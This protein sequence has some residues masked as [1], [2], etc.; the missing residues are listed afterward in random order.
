MAEDRE[1]LIRWLNDAHAMEQAQIPVL[2]NHAK[3]A[4]GFPHIRARDEQHVEE[5]RRHAE[6]VRGCLQRLGETPSATKSLLG[7][8]MGNV[9]SVMTGAFRDELV[10]NFLMDHAAENLEIASYSALVTAAREVGEEEIA[11]TCE[12][13]L[14]EEEAMAGW[15]RENLPTAVRET[16]RT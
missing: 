10:K 1:I 5:T 16:L 14:R 15:L 3:D 13:I 8:M 6:L 7:S 9:Q 11:R 12:E 2:E 4:E